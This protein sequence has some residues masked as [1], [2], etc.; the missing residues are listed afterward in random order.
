MRKRLFFVTS[1][2]IVFQ[3][4]C[5]NDQENKIFQAINEL[6]NYTSDD[7]SIEVKSILDLDLD[8][9][10]KLCLKHP[11]ADKIAWVSVENIRSGRKWRIQLERNR[12]N[13]IWSKTVDQMITEKKVLDESIRTL[14][15]IIG[16]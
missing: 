8:K 11:S 3:I 16:K 14:K 2:I 7:H 6:Y 12:R 15:S 5:V 13:G 4:S 1:L 9:D 10:R